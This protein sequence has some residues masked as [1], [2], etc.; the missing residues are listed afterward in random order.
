MSRPDLVTRGVLAAHRWVESGLR[1]LRGL[2]DGLVLGL[3]DDRRLAALDAAYYDREGMYVD[4]AYNRSGLSPWE[5]SAIDRWFPPGCRVTVVGAGGGREVLALL[6][7]GYDA[8]G[9][10]PH[11]DL[12]AFGARLTEQA[13]HGRRVQVC[14][15]DGWPATAPKAD[16]VVVGWG[17]YML[18]P[19]RDR[20]I[21]FLRAAAASLPPG[22]PVLLSF[23]PRRGTAV[24]FRVSSSVGS[25]LRRLRGR[26]PVEAGDALEPN[27]V[28]FFSGAQVESELADAGFRPVHIAFENYGWAV[29]ELVACTDPR[30]GDEG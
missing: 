13:G 3:L 2:F 21:A 10:E 14:S 4:E 26:Q 19:G 30:R 16:A 7:Q 23:F 27:F 12:A 5:Q 15:R 9:F 1:A 22:G 8:I 25:M 18:M 11:P 6:D 29:A 28:H 20:R 24:R 17:A